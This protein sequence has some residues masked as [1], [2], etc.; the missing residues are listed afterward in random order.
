MRGSCH[1]GI[2]RD[3]GL[4]GRTDVVTCGTSEETT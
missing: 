2:D 1:R 3:P 4:I